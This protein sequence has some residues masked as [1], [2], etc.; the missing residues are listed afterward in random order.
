[1]TTKAMND[2]YNAQ[3]F[4]PMAQIVSIPEEYE[5][6]EGHLYRAVDQRV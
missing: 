3:P 2:G 4:F 5:C 6:E 1:M